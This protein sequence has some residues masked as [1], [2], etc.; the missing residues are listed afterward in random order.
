MRINLKSQI[1]CCAVAC[2]FAMPAAA[3][4]VNLKLAS[5]APA[6]ALINQVFAGWAERVN[7]AADG[8]ITIEFIPGGVLGKEGQMLDRVAAG[9]VDIAWDFQGYYPGKYPKS[10]V[11]EQPFQFETAEQGSRALQELFENGT[12]TGEYQ[13]VK[14]LGLFTFPNASVM[15]SEPLD[16][17]SNLSGRKIT[18]QNPTMQAAAGNLGATPV[19]IGIPEWYQ[20]LSRGTIDGAIVTFTAVPAFRL[21]EVMHFYIDVS[22]G[23]NPG[24]FIMNQAKFDAL[25][26]AGQRAIAANSGHS[27]AVEMGSFLDNW[28]TNAKGM[29]AQ[30]DN[31]LVELSEAELAIWRDALTP[32]GEAWVARTEDGAAIAEAF[33]AEIAK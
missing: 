22:V 23:G 11:V 15:L 2:M 20:A 10:G 8:A 33:Q 26:E 24:M 14:V 6:P 21:N 1:A 32:L 30:G 7:A 31:Q 18:A 19:N 5:P 29:A 3:Q 9:V 28:N 4:T 13:D 27:F 12:I 25:P 17:L 16:D